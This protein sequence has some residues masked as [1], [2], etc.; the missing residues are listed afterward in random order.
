[1]AISIATGFPLDQVVNWTA[2]SSTNSSLS[3][4]PVTVGDFMLCSIFYTGASFITNLSGGGCTGWQEVPGAFYHNTGSSVGSAALWTATVTSTSAQ[5]ITATVNSAPSGTP[6]FTVDA[7]ELTGYN[8]WGVDVAG[9]NTA[10][11]ATV[12]GPSLT[13]SGLWGSEAYF[14]G[15]ANQ[16]GTS[17]TGGTGGFTYFHG[18]SSFVALAYLLGITS[19][20]GSPSMTITS[21]GWDA[22]AAIV[23]G[24]ASART[25]VPHRMPLGA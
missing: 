11:S 21:G 25:F 17:Y 5:A 22:V 12:S 3:L 24:G 2:S 8:V 4:T 16:T 23:T 10:T 15:F 20:S 7:V 19:A 9:T 18:S 1:M 13:P 14:C 6:A